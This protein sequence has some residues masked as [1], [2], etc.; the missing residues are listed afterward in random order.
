MEKMKK[1]KFSIRK[2]VYNDKYL[3][4]CSIIAAII[5]WIITSLNL[6]PETTKQ[7]SVPV[8]IDFSGT[9]AEQLGIE[10]YGDKEI[11]VD[12]TIS[13]KKYLA[14]DINESDL[15]ATLQTSTVTSTGY[16][17]VPI[18]VTP[19]DAAAEFRIER[20]SPTS[21]QGY[22]DV[23]QEI[24]MPVDI[25]FVNGSFTADGYVAGDTTLNHSSVLL[26]GPKDY[27]SN[28]KSVVADVTLENDLTESQI[29]NLE[30]KAVDSSGNEVR[31]I[32]LTVPE[33]E[34]SVVATIPILKVQLLKP[35]VTFVGGSDDA[36]SVL[37]V[38]YSVDSVQVGALESAALTTL[39]LGNISFADL[40]VGTNTFDFD[41]NAIN[42]ITVLDGT[43][44]ITVTVTV[45]DDYSTKTISISRS[46]IN[47]ELLNYNV[48]VRG[49]SSNRITIVGDSDVLKDID[50]SKISLSLAPANGE[51]VISEATT[52]CRIAI[53]INVQGTCWVIGTYTANVSVTPK[54]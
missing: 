30:P 49:L 43:S 16:L 51:D 4:V 42:G 52:E 22:F 48:S 54:Q 44:T 17:S 33:G 40:N 46:D 26:S 12:V 37:D 32:T 41:A 47:S 53:S 21:A 29:V 50:K 6:S 28:V 3:I 11:T 25:N 8:T 27:I 38:E 18:T 23:A 36:E 31:Y 19:F 34:S 35:S 7:I 13:C 24:S 10:Y 5:I 15:V 39:N 2:L 9:L 20:H 1:N 14:K 45:P